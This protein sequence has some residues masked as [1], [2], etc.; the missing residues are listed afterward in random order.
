MERGKPGSKVYVLSDAGGLPLRGGLSVADTHVSLAWK[1][2][3]SHFHMGHEL[4]AMDS[5]PERLHADRVF[6]TCGDGCEAS[7]SASAS[8]AKASSP[9]RD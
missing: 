3:L 9:A 7:A 4:H 1:P 6:F 2:M 8:P 5:K